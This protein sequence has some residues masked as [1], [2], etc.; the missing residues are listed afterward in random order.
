V[1]VRW[2]AKE[3]FMVDGSSAADTAEA[4]VLLECTVSMDF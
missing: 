1:V 4:F 3:R 2:D